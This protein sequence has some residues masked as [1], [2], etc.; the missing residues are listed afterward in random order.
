MTESYP[1]SAL[2]KQRNDQAGGLIRA[3]TNTGPVGRF[4]QNDASFD[5]LYP[6]HLQQISSRHWT[7]L[8]VARAAAAYLAVPGSRILDIGS[9]TG[10]FCLTAAELHPQCHFFGA[11][12]RE[13]LVEYADRALQYLALKNANFKHVNVTQ[14]DFNRFDH[15]YFYNAFYENIDQQ[16]AIDERVE[17][18]R[19]LYD[20]YANYIHHALKHRPAGTRVV[21]YQ[22]DQEIIPASYKLVAMSFK[23]M[24]K[25]WISE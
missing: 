16:H 9:G 13:E 24:L 19:S 6:K 15:F 23:Q 3:L 18:S 17:L 22:A 14:V 7:P 20:Y 1:S 10:K 21:T 12:H 2:P 8:K 25:L 4:F 11:E 5:C